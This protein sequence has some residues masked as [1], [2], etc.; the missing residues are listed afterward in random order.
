ML[1]EV[2]TAVFD[3]LSL[4]DILTKAGQSH[5]L[6]FQVPQYG[7]IPSDQPPS[8]LEG[9][10]FRL[11]GTNRNSWRNRR[12]KYFLNPATVIFRHDTREDILTQNLV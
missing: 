6:P 7:V 12:Q 5:N 10:D 11:V 9:E 1:Y 3:F 8:P 4:G 2:I